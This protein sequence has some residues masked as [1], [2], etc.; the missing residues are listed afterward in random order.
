MKPVLVLLS[1]VAVAVGVLVF[2]NR[3]EEPQVADPS[4]AGPGV[5]SPAVEDTVAAPELVATADEDED[6]EA[7][8][9]VADPEDPTRVS[10]ES[11]PSTKS[12]GA[13]AERPLTVDVVLPAGHPASEPV[14]VW[15]L[16]GHGH[17][18]DL[19]EDVRLGEG[20][21]DVA[22]EEHPWSRSTWSPTGVE[23]P[24]PEGATEATVVAVSRFLVPAPIEIR[25]PTAGAVEPPVL[26]P[27]LG[28]SV[29]VRVEL[30]EGA[31]L[32]EYDP[33]SFRTDLERNSH[34]EIQAQLVTAWPRMHRQRGGLD[35][36]WSRSLRGLDV[37]EG[38]HWTVSL[39]APGF[40]DPEDQ[41]PSLTAGAV[42]TVEFRPAWG[43]DLE[44]VVQGPEQEPVAQAQVRIDLDPTSHLHTHS[45][46][47]STASS[48]DEEGRARFEG[49]AAGAWSVTVMADSYLWE[50][51]EVELV[52]R[53]EQ[54][55]EIALSRG[56]SVAGEVRFPD[57][58]PAPD[59][60]VDVRFQE[61]R[62]LGNG[63][64]TYNTSNGTMS[65]AEGG[66]VVTGFSEATSIQGIEAQY[67]VSDEAGAEASGVPL[68]GSLKAF[69]EEAAIGDGHVLTLEPTLTLTGRLVGEDGAGITGDVSLTAWPVGE[70]R[71]GGRGIYEHANWSSDVG[72]GDA[73]DP[74]AFVLDGFSPGEW[75]FQCESDAHRA[76]E[77]IRVTIPQLEPLEITLFDKAA[78]AGVVVDPSGAPVPGASV[79]LSP[80]D[81][82]FGRRIDE[83]VEA[84]SDGTFEVRAD[85]AQTMI[86]AEHVDWASSEKLAL[87]LSEG[88]SSEP[89]TLQLRVG[90]TITGVVRDEDGAPWAGRMVVAM[91]G[92]GGALMAMR[93]MG[94]EP[95][96]VLTGADGRF[97]LE[98]VDPG[99]VTVT[100]APSQEEIERR[101]ESAGGES[102]ALMF[103]IMGELVSETV[104]VADGETVDV[105][106]GA[107][108]KRPVLLSG[109][110]L[111]GD[112]PVAAQLI[113]LAD[114]GPPMAGAKAAQTGEDGRYELE[115]DN[116]GTYT[117][118]VNTQDV[119]G[120]G[121]TV[122]VTV[123]EV[124]AHRQD[125]RLAT[126]V[127]RGR[128]VGPDGSGAGNI[129]V[130]LAS[131][132]LSNSP[133]QMFL[134]GA[135]E[136]NAD[137]SFEL[138]AVKPGSYVLRA[139]VEA[140]PGLWSERAAYG[141]ALLEGVV[142]GDGEVVDGLE[143]R[144][145]D[146]GE[147][148]GVVLDAEGTPVVGADVF[149]RDGRGRAVSLL[150][151][152]RTDVSGSFRV[153]GLAA[154]EVTLF[155]RKGDAV[156]RD[157]P[158]VSITAGGTAKCSL[159]MVAGTT[160]VVQAERDGEAVRVQV[161]VVDDAGRDWSGLWSEEDLMT[162][163]GEGSSGTESRIGPLPAG[164]YT[165]IAT[166]LDGAT[167]A[168]K[169]VTLREGRPE[170]SLKMRLR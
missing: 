170:R 163:M 137:G 139:N 97:V 33:R 89:I 31:V 21:A 5:S 135:A 116:P 81:D 22:G 152:A 69:L 131:E 102:E 50:T 52:A 49:V 68:G 19:A 106:L 112:R 104:E 122:S 146:G 158:P 55:L 111:R 151:V 12:F 150:A 10:V 117:F 63:S 14:E 138:V 156:T 53:E 86:H 93:M 159:E 144:L 70:E 114:E 61:V 25:V 71:W 123:P 136:T 85:G 30:P 107:T 9:S 145:T 27:V 40:V 23:L 109:R 65:D 58:S 88:A 66:F 16:F 28:A 6:A 32:G 84:G 82:P 169:T 132:R 8:V 118:V 115:L 37:A 20:V 128:V 96:P 7:V 164:R 154:G 120:E 125:I 95:E 24:V 15:A 38:V 167:T 36:D 99:K 91:P 119:S 79:L 98:H 54:T 165:A 60:R 51:R 101:M 45:F 18:H 121:E 92:P 75:N 129:A 83:M 2:L 140:E 43:A 100:A 141:H 124:D 155:A 157:V 47:T 17:H 127:V 13:E 142:V 73:D 143:L 161:S 35:A 67:H 59:A 41:V 80:E 44:V 153:Q 48:T 126:G 133:L 149:A 77:P 87:D 76:L 147:V 90:A 62:H 56:L 46:T 162:W 94:P 166:S 26:S 57:G 34:G 4:V 11:G 134:N 72:T 74:G 78:I 29:E 39:S 64:T 108:P 103:E 148:E 110:V 3:G 105:E 130:F 113:V 1:L 168:K 42:A 160:L